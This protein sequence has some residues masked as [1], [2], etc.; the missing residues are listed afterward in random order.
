MMKF[1][2]PLVS[3]I[4]IKRYKRFLADFLIDGNI[5]VAH[6]ANTGAMTSCLGENWPALLS[7]S[8]SKTRKLKHSFE[9][10]FNGISW[11]GVNT[12]RANGLA[13]E[14]ISNGTIIELQGYSNLNSEVKIG[15]SRIDI[16]LSNGEDDQCFVEVKNVT[17]VNKEFQCL[18]PDSVTERGQKHLSELIALRKMGI[19]AVMLFIVQRE[20]CSSFKIE[21]SIDP[22]YCNLLKEALLEGVEVLVYQ[23]KLSPHEIF[24]HKK[25]ELI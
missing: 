7:L 16:H 23:C 8:D 12:S 24:V 6:T 10:I 5:I 17:L 1:N 3:A 14:A 15:K 11:I 25:I 22:G 13:I 9:M 21:N 18:F 4:F 19:R 2:T 20:D